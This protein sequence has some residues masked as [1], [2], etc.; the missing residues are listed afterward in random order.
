MS[1]AST[2]QRE[3]AEMLAQAVT[4]MS[5]EDLVAMVLATLPCATVHDMA[6]MARA[7]SHGSLENVE[8]DLLVL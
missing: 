1:K 2:V 7:T 5:R 8:F 6:E 4:K 3:T